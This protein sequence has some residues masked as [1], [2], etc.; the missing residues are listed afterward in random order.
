MSLRIIKL[1]IYSVIIKKMLSYK[2]K[3]LMNI[4]ELAHFNH[5]LTYFDKAMLN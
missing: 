2:L 3:N 4:K 5:L 1:S